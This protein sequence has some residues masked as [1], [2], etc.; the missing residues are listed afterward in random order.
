MTAMYTPLPKVTFYTWSEFL[1]RVGVTPSLVS[2]LERKFYEEKIELSQL[3]Q[4]NYQ[5]LTKLGVTLGDAA[6]IMNIA[7]KVKKYSKS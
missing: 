2:Q 4:L 1:S 5:I 7:K 3:S 6:K